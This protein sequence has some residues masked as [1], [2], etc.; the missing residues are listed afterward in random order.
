M[1]SMHAWRAGVRLRSAGLLAAGGDPP[2]LGC[3]LPSLTCSAFLKQ[4]QFSLSFQS[5]TVL[6][7]P[8]CF[9]QRAGSA[10]LLMGQTGRF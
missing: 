6:E 1:L 10:A 7:V 8:S 5:S 9:S 4:M 2:F 3:R